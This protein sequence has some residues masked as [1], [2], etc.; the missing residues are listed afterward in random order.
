M[1]A[2]RKSA[3]KARPAAAPASSVKG[4]TSS[5]AVH[6]T[7]SSSWRH[8]FEQFARTASHAAGKPAAFFAAVT[9]IVVWL[10]SGP[11]FGFSD[12]WQLVINTGTTIITFLMVFLLQHSQN[13]DTMALQVKLGELIIAL[14]GAHNAVATA[15]D[16]SE[17]E[18][19]ELHAHHAKQAAETLRRLEA[20]HGTKA[21]AALIKKAADIQTRH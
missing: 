11:I 3:S 15:E 1:K 14:K 8:W 4:E 18:L 21:A 2:V 13:R 16:L 6:P 17:E 10:I 12:T 9:I 19:A 5:N 7:Q 20:T